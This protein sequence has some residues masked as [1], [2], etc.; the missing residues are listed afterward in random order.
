[1]AQQKEISFS[2]KAR[3]FQLGTVHAKTKNI[4]F[5]LHGYGQLG[6]FFIRKFNVLE[7]DETCIIAPEG[8]SRFYLTDN[9][10]R[11]GATWMTKE[12][13]LMEIDNYLHYL[14]GIY[15]EVIKSASTP[16]ITILGFSQGAATASR[17]TVSRPNLAQRLILWAGIF[18]PDLDFEKGSEIL[19]A[20]EVVEVYGTTDPYLTDDKFKE[21]ISLNTKLKLNATMIQFEG[22]HEM[23]EKILQQLR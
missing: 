11:V 8:L 7:N 6:E 10:G 18:P 4:W 17:W 12:N 1:M 5:V 14:N 21:M 22:G 19:N 13:R 16:K 3:Y 15:N 23:N 20:M 2:F 9:S